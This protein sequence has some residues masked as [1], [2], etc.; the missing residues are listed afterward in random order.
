MASTVGLY[1]NPEN[2]YVGIGTTTPAQKMVVYGGLNVSGNVGIGTTVAGSALSVV[3]DMSVSGTLTA[4]PRMTILQDQKTAA[5]GG[6]SA[7][8][9]QKRTLNTTV[10][11]SIGVSLTTNNFTLP[12]GT[13]HIVASAPCSRA[14]E[15]KIVLSTSDNSTKLLH[16]TSEY[17]NATTLVQTRSIIDSILTLVTPTTVAIWHYMISGYAGNGLGIVTGIAPEIYTTIRITKLV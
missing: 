10:I 12:E 16:G 4:Y 2:L 17:N 9:W 7:A 3:G 5:A 6:T 11:D 14:Q 13:Y 15:H 1:V 8:G